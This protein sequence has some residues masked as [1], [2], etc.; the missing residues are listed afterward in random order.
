MKNFR[1]RER[2]PDT[3]LRLHLSYPVRGTGRSLGGQISFVC[4]FRQLH[5]T[6]FTKSPCVSFVIETRRRTPVHPKPINLTSLP[7]MKILY[8]FIPLSF[9][10]PSA[11]SPSRPSGSTLPRPYH[12]TCW[13]RVSGQPIHGRCVL[14]TWATKCS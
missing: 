2:N 5:V 3:P 7:T 9:V 6:Q 8:V 11:R 4:F 13:S 10:V 1:S 12:V 14:R